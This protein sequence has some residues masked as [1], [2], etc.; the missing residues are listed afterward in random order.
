M[1]FEAKYLIRW[2]I[3]GWMLIFWIVTFLVSTY[4]NE[5]LS[6]FNF[7]DLGKLVGVF[8]SLGVFGVALGYIIHQ[9]YFAL[10]WITN[11]TR[12]FENALKEV[13]DF[14]KPENWG[15]NSNKDYFYFEYLWHR[16]L[17]ELNEEKRTYI[18]GRYRYLLSTV[19]GLGTIFVS[20][21]LSLFF[22]ILSAIYIFGISSIPLRIDFLVAL[23]IVIILVVL[24]N[25]NYYSAN[26]N[27]IQGKFLN[28]MLN[29]EFK[30]SQCEREG[31]NND[32]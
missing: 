1:N 4:Y 25:F 7:L 17:L 24:L 19:H 20:H 30:D 26:L 5:I 27:Y 8:I 12:I 22:T 13:D 11:K 18:V 16:N 29:K 15:D 10:N 6:K 2:G 3:P 21:L 9:L 23:Q 32:L 14:P 28:T 31:I